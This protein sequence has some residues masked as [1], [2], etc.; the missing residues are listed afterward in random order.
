MSL[1]VQER[2]RR[3]QDAEI[4][5]SLRAGVQR[6]TAEDGSLALPARTWVAAATA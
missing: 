4:V 2:S 1:R 5:E 6:W 3:D